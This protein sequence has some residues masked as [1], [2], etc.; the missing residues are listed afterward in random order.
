LIEPLTVEY[1]PNETEHLVADPILQLEARRV[2]IR[3]LAKS[4]KVSEETVKAARR[5]KRVRK[6]A[7]K[8]S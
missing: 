3:T 6:S 7:L 8:N 4:A 5:G 2:S 1:R